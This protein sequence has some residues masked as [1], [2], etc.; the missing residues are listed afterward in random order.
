MRHIFTSLLILL[1]VSAAAEAFRVDLRKFNATHPDQ[2]VGLNCFV[3]G[4]QFLRFESLTLKDSKGRRISAAK[5]KKISNPPER[6]NELIQEDVSHSLFTRYTISGNECTIQWEYDALP[7]P[8]GRELRLE[9]WFT[10]KTKLNTSTK[11]KIFKSRELSGYTPVAS[12][13]ISFAESPILPVIENLEKAKWAPWAKCHRI[14]FHLPYDPATG[15]RGKCAMK[16]TLDGSPENMFYVIPVWQYGNRELVDQQAGDGKGG[17]TDQGFRDMRTFRPGRYTSCGIPFEVGGKVVILNG[18]ERPQFPV[19]SPEIPLNG[20]CAERLVFFHA[21]AWQPRQ[22]GAKVMSY[23]IRYQDG[24]TVTCPVFADKD[25]GDWFAPQDNGNKRIAWSGDASFG[26]VGFHQTQWH[27]PHPEKPLASLRAVSAKERSVPI[28]LGITV[29]RS[30][31][32]ESFYQAYETLFKTRP[33]PDIDIS[34]WYPVHMPWEKPIL[35]G[36]A[37]D[38][39]FLNPGPAGKEGFLRVNNAG[40]FEFAES[41]GREVRFWGVNVVH[42]GCYPYKRDAE[43]IAALLAARGFNLVRFHHWGYT[44][45]KQFKLYPWTEKHRII[46]PDGTLNPEALDRMDYFI[47]QLKKHGIYISF[48]LNEAFRWELFCKENP[49]WSGDAGTRLNKESLYNR[50]L[51]ENAKRLAKIIFF[52]KN[53]YTG[54]SLAEDPVLALV[55]LVN[56]TTLTYNWSTPFK[57]NSRLQSG[58]DELN[59]LWLNYQKERGVKNPLELEGGYAQYSFGETGLRF[60]AGLQKKY[61]EEMRIFLKESGINVPIGGPAWMLVLPDMWSCRNMDFLDQHAYHGSGP[62]IKGKWP[63]PFD[64]SL[65]DAIFSSMPYF[66]QIARM[67]MKGK[68]QMISEWDFVY[69]GNHRCQGIPLMAAIA[70][71]QE[72]NAPIHFALPFRV[73][74]DPQWDT[75]IEVNRN[76]F[77]P[78]IAGFFPAGGLAFRRFD[79]APARNCIE[80]RYPEKRIFENRNFIEENP[81]FTGMVK[82]TNSILDTDG[83]PGWPLA[84]TMKPEELMKFTAEKFNIPLT[85]DYTES[86][87]KQ[88]RRFLNPGLWLVDSERTQMAVGNLSSLGYKNRELSAFKIQS[89][90]TFASMVFS[91]LDGKALTDSS[92]ILLT[93]VGNSRNSGSVIRGELH[94]KPGTGPALVQPLEAKITFKNRKQERKFFILDP[95]TGARR[96]MIPVT[97]GSVRIDKSARSIYFEIVRE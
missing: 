89:P 8:E 20:V 35:P 78:S 85:G 77:D 2:K 42:S 70:S 95:E 86:D 59:S 32:P 41:P 50:N 13:R 61:F 71:H 36:S 24:T 10:S 27:N 45:V 87:T 3:G 26:E 6:L 31:A 65:P 17:W 55:Q 48:G 66:T 57:R 7:N 1:A 39:S 58:Y 51:I 30:G 75:R 76:A 83:D 44:H 21:M 94:E 90:E 43:R 67:R 62:R 49:G 82:V 38:F 11:Q 91:S 12:F 4:V 73:L 69:P 22:Y 18:Q 40:K 60:F 92:R 56:E 81:F 68:P 9:I 29:V 64:V 54:L 72:W 33:S 47:Y 74:F 53:P 97:N 79:I 34:S 63:G 96:Q 28:L 52:R 88:I 80:I 15:A 14:I 37:L 5:P 25:I 93:F 23:E 19:S 16:I 84:S 46:L